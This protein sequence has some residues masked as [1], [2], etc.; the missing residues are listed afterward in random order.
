MTNQTT[1]ISY[2]KSSVN[3]DKHS[4]PNQLEEEQRNLVSVS[5]V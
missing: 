4:D 2:N 3:G 5:F 1:N